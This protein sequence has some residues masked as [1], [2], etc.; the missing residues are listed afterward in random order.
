MEINIDN[1]IVD[2][3]VGINTEEL[4]HSQSQSSDGAISP[5]LVATST[6]RNRQTAA[7]IALLGLILFVLETG[8]QRWIGRSNIINKAQLPLVKHTQAMIR[9]SILKR[10]H[11]EPDMKS[12]AYAISDDT[13]QEYKQWHRLVRN[14]SQMELQPSDW[15]PTI[16]NWDHHPR[17]RSDRFPSVDERVQYYMGK[18]YNASIPMYGP[19]FLKDTY[20]QRKTTREYGTFSDILVNLYNLEKEKLYKCYQNKKELH[21]MSPYCRDYIDLAILHKGGTANVLHNIGDALPFVPEEIRKY[22][23]FAKVRPYCK[24]KNIGESRASRLGNTLCKQKKKTEPIILPLNRKRHFSAASIVPE[25]DVPWEKKVSIAVWRGQYGKTHDTISDTNDIKYAL[26]SKHLNSTLVNARFSKHTKDAPAEMIGSYMDGKDQLKYKYIISIEGNDV[27]SGLKWMLFSNSVV[28]TPEFTW[29]SWAMEGRL[30]PFK[31]YIPL[32]SDMS[33]VEEM[34]QWAEKHPEETR[35][36]SERSTLFMYDLLFHPD[37]IEDEREVIM[38]I[39]E[40]FEKNFGSHQ[41]VIQRRA[42]LNIQWNKH[43][44]D[45]A[46]RFPSIEERVKFAMGKWYRNEDGVSMKRSDSENMLLSNV[47]NDISKG[48]LFIAS[49]QQLTGCSIGWDVHR[50]CQLSLPDFDERNTA[51]LKSNSF[52]R[53]RKTK[54]GKHIML[55]PKSSWREGDKG[56]KESKRVLLDDLIKVLCYGE[57][58]HEG[59]TFPFFSSSR[60]NNDAILWP[61]DADNS[62][63]V[64]KSGWVEEMDTDFYN[65]KPAAI[66]SSVHKFSNI[67]TSGNVTMKKFFLPDTDSNQKD[68]IRGMLSYR[69][70]LTTTQEENFLQDLL[71]MLLSQSVV[72]MPKKRSVD[73][74]LMEGFLEPYVHFVPI[75][76]DYSDM[77]EKIQWCEDNLDEAKVISERATLFV[78]DM[79]FDE[80]SERENEEVKFRVME[81]YSK[82]FG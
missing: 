77:N 68:R 40:T 24:N 37:A 52:N 58:V 65:K 19:D 16:H 9:K 28:M 5:K 2:H 66:P 35:L 82:L 25:N 11:G 1:S 27:S 22:P 15:T 72:L 8:V 38:N 47:G 33:N 4:H 21:V 76:P 61:L 23:M 78:H 41:K 13:K 81:R 54:K 60:R 3:A 75:E 57:C 42:A 51:D 70:F 50:L 34:I 67:G 46:S 64:V 17:R 10:S 44:T 73:S 36:I 6:Q 45:R 26:V 29:E 14:M 69:Y 59:A 18:W 55:A 56:M 79:L 43:P 39:M 63:G 80:S 30:E 20:I 62:V 53:L 48:N 31:H 12:Y 32:K 7:K 74:W 71:W 49:G